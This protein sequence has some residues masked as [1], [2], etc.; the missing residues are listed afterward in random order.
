MTGA[1]TENK[2]RNVLFSLNE[3]VIISEVDHSKIQ[4]Y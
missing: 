1:R 3:S 2:E 4:D